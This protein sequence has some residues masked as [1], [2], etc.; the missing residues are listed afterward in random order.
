MLARRQE[1]EVQDAT[2]I[3]VH[4]YGRLRRYGPTGDVSVACVVR[5]EPDADH[6]TVGDLIA[7][8]GIS[9]PEVGS[10]FRDGHWEREGLSTSLRGARRLGLF[11]PEMGL[12]YV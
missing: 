3:E 2:V 4:L 1:T 10:V 11:P 6:Q 9:G 12:L 8:L 7:A 5:V